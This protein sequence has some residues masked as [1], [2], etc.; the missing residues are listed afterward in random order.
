MKKPDLPWSIEESAGQL[1]RAR[2][3][4][5]KAERELKLAYKEW[6]QAAHAYDLAL[7]KKIVELRNFG[8]AAT[9]CRDLA[10]GDPEV[11]DLRMIR[12]TKEGVKEAAEQACWRRNAD[13]K[14]TQALAGWSERR[15]FAEARG[16][17]V[18]SFERPIGA[19]A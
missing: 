17:V 4:Q 10:K 9:L 3:N 11:A 13:R 12:D 16:D 7:A 5:E 6:A 2:V 1:H 15:E 14:D 18:Q 8:Q 19:A